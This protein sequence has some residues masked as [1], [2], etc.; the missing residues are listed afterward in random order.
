MIK[1]ISLIKSYFQNLTAP[2]IS[3]DCESYNSLWE[4]KIKLVWPTDSIWQHRSGS[5]LDQVMARCLMVPIIACCLFRPSHF[6]NQWWH[7]VNQTLRDTFQWNNIW[8]LKV[9]VKKPTHLKILSAK[10]QPFY[11][12][13]N[14]LILRLN[15]CKQLG[16]CVYGLMTS[17]GIHVIPVPNH[18]GWWKA[19]VNLIDGT[20]DSRAL[21]KL[22]RWDKSRCW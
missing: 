16:L 4:K 19:G 18:V 17:A 20:A 3:W 13:L 6:L 21:I 2:E 1:Y 8:N 11:R 15:P 10:W 5:T 12:G 22:L 9:F 7:I 14:V